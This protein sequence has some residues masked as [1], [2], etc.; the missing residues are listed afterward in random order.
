MGRLLFRLRPAVLFAI[1]LSLWP[2]AD[3]ALLEP[4][5]FLASEP[6][7]VTAIFTRCGPGRGHACVVDGDTFKLGQR[8]VR[9][10]GIDAPEV[11]G[12]CAEERKLAEAATVRLQALLN[13]GPFTMTGRIDDM[14]DRYGRD[15]RAVTR[16]RADG[17]VQSVAEEMRKSGL[18]RRYLGYKTDWCAA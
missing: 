6:E 11:Q 18:A 12:R 13:Q 4:I 16:E 2:A 3:P 14:S 5:G 10:I 9:I 7:R 1:L 17:S 8:K 15:L